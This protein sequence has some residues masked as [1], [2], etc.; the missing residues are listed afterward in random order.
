MYDCHCAD[1]DIP[2]MTPNSVG[3]PIRITLWNGSRLARYRSRETCSAD[4]TP[5]SGRDR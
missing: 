1:A 4:I 3:M 2:A 5:I